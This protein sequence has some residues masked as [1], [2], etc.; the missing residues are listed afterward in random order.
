MRVHQDSVQ[1]EVVT[2]LAA[3]TIGQVHP[4]KT[5]M[6]GQRDPVS[7][8]QSPECHNAQEVVWRYR[9]CRRNHHRT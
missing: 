4:T 3:A 5:R 8:R 6:D 1:A 9:G 7:R 2:L